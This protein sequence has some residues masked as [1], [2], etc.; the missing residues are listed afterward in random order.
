MS[1][2]CDLATFIKK[3]D[4][5]REVMYRSG[6]TND[7]VKVIAHADSMSLDWVNQDTVECLLG[8][9][10]YE[11]LRNV[12]TVVKRNLTYRADL[13]GHEVVKSPGALVKMGIGDCKSFS[14]LIGAILKSLG[15]KYV[16]RF[17][18]YEKGDVTHVY[19]VAMLNGKEVILDAVHTR[20]DEEVKYYRKKDMRPG[21]SASGIR[22]KPTQPFAEGANNNLFNYAALAFFAWA[23][24]K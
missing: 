22:Q 8:N 19:P 17:A 6:G 14:L 13:P 16:Y 9:T 1:R 20:F 7:I 11:T 18:A 15:F 2:R 24:L 3:S 12:W 10:E 21:G 5:K 4:L 23:L